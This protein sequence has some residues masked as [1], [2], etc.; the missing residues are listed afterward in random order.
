V[1]PIR[2]HSWL[3]RAGLLVLSVL[4]ILIFCELT[5]R[6]YQYARYQVPIIGDGLDQSSAEKLH[7]IARLPNILDQR[8]GWRGTPNYRYQ[9]QEQNPDGSFYSLVVSKNSMGFRA[10]GALSTS[11]P[12]VFVLG[13]SFTEALQV[14]DN[15]TYYAILG[16][17][18]DCEIFATGSSGYGSLQE[19][20][21]LDQFID[22]IHPDLILW[23]F[24][25]NDFMD[26]SYNLGRQWKA[27]SLSL[28]RP[29]WE[30]GKIVYRLPRPFPWLYKVA[31]RWS[32]FL[33]LL[34]TRLD[35]LLA[36]P[37]GQDLLLK[38][39]L[40][41]GEKHPGFAEA[42]EITNQI[43]S[44]VANRAGTTPVVVF[45]S[46]TTASPF[47][48]TIHEIAIRH[49]MFFVKNLPGVLDL[50]AQKGRRLYSSDKIHWN[51]EGH[52]LVAETICQFLNKNTLLRS[53]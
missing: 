18:L 50:E 41:E 11:K 33:P 22:Q 47:Y 16:K 34:T 31:N 48:P 29:F 44:K 7:P 9:G 4:L 35:R 40:Q 25:Y 20:M 32:R 10:F 12:K 21:L 17:V 28:E 30:K 3:I 49:G 38:A 45:E 14:S 19:Y 36:P 53:H 23:Q 26:N 15:E 13:D 1:S 6:I 2:R 27:G 46:G 39:I 52:R 8:L 5:V 24:C 43:M 42:V 37:P 51:Q